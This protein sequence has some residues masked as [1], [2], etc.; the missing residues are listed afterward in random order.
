MRC[1]SILVLLAMLLSLFPLQAFAADVGS[2]AAAADY[3]VLYM[4]WTG[5]GSWKVGSVSGSSV[6][7]DS[8]STASG[9]LYSYYKWFYIPSAGES[10]LSGSELYADV[11]SVHRAL[12]MDPIS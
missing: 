10:G 4:S 2:S 8:I 11:N 12:G 3:M 5:T 6:R 7:T 9:E 1:L